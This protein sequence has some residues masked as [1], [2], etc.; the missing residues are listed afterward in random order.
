[1][2]GVLEVDGIE[3]FLGNL[4][5]MMEASDGDGAA[6]RSFVAG[7]WGRFGTADVGVGDLHELSLAIEP[8]PPLGTG[9]DRSQRI[10]LG[11]ALGRMRDRV[12]A[13]DGYEL[14][15]V[16]LGVSH[17]AKRWQLSPKSDRR[18]AGNAQSGE[19]LAAAGN[20]QTK[21]SPAQPVEIIGSGECGN[22]G[23][24]SNPTR[25]RARARERR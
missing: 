4:D 12:F 15:I 1:M 6:W 11:K 24:F 22:V 7:W 13:I 8:P 2:G 3:G 16:M 14:R 9:G 5:E 25:A 18:K 17:Q 19:C 20:V 21:H 23:M 10:R